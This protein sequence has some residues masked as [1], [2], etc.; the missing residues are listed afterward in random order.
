MTGRYDR[1]GPDGRQAYDDASY[2]PAQPHLDDRYYEDPRYAALAYDEARDHPQGEGA[3]EEPYPYGDEQDAGSGP[4]WTYDESRKAWVDR[5]GH[6]YVEPAGDGDEGGYAPAYEEDEYLAPQEDAQL[7][8]RRSRSGVL[9]LA[10][11]VLVASMGGGLA[12]AWKKGAFIGSDIPGLGGPPP[13]IRASTDPVKIKPAETTAAVDQPNPQIFG[14]KDDTP[15]IGQEKLVSHDEQPVAEVPVRTDAVPV[16]TASINPATMPATGALP[17]PANDNTASTPTRSV[18]TS[19]ITLPAPAAGDTGDTPEGDVP[20]GPRRVKTIKIMGDNTVVT[21]EAPIAGPNPAPS[22]ARPIDISGITP[23]APLTQAE[24]QVPD[25]A[26]AA[27]ADSGQAATVATPSADKP[28]DTT[29][30]DGD[31]GDSADATTVV[32]PTRS[33]E[34]AVAP[35]HPAIPP[36]RPRNIPSAPA[37]VAAPA[38]PTQ[39]ASAEPVASPIAGTGFV[40]QVSSQKTPAD[41]QTAYQALQR[42]FPAVIGGLKLSVR[43]VDI[44]DRGTYYRVRVGL[45]ASS[46]EAQAFCAKLKAAGGDCVVA[47]N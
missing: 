24:Q 29:A 25:P 37:P 7:P 30:N 39:V 20:D 32:T 36:V 45:W 35:V 6:P 33:A 8:Q 43:K 41:A 4:E 16:R 44:A 2:D 38:K 47:R 9:G 27:P 31:G 14:R 42:R 19:N 15:S 18:S 13:V 5:D 22:T 34:T 28:A 21:G 26:A 11:L 40:V 1:G 12:Y 3:Y 23:T 17:A 10:A 46:N